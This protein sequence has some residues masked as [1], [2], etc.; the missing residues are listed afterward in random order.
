[1]KKLRVILLVPL[2]FLLTACIPD[3]GTVIDKYPIDQAKTRITICVRSN[4]KGHREG[5]D[6]F[7]PSEVRHCEIGDEWPSCKED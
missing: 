1:M 4:E 3:H 5:C 7:K 6:S 2:L